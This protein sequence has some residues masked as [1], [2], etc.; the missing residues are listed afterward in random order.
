M[1]RPRE[2]LDTQELTHRTA[3]EDSHLPQDL[4]LSEQKGSA[5]SNKRRFQR[6]E[7]GISLGTMPTG[8]KIP[9]FQKESVS[10]FRTTKN[11]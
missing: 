1:Q 10:K 7:G 6:K 9:L 8:H 11:F 3:R 5:P 4:L 2:P